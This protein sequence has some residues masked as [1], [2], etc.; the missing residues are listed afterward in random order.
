MIGF[1]KNNEKIITSGDSNIKFEELH[2][3]LSVKTNDPSF[4]WPFAIPSEP[5]LKTFNFPNS[6]DNI[7]NGFESEEGHTTLFGNKW[8]DGLVKVSSTK[9][10]F[11]NIVFSGK[12]GVLSKY[13]DKTITE[14]LGN[15]LI[16]WGNFEDVDN[17]IVFPEVAF[18]DFNGFYN[19]DLS[20]IIIPFFKLHYIMKKVFYSLGY[21]FVDEITSNDN[22][23]KKASI[24]C[25]RVE[26]YWLYNELIPIVDQEWKIKDFLPDW[27][28]SEFIQSIKI[29]F[30]C[31]VDISP[32]DKTITFTTFDRLKSKPPAHYSL[33]GDIESAPN[34][35]SNFGLSFSGGV[36]EG[37]HQSFPSGDYKGS[38][39]DFDSL[40]DI[41]SPSIG[42]YAFVSFENR[43]YEYVEDVVLEE[44]LWTHSHFPFH[45]YN[46]NSEN[47]L[48]T[49]FIPLARMTREYI[50]LSSS[51]NIEDNGSGKVR[52]TGL[53]L[54]TGVSVFLREQDQYST[55]TAYTVTDYD[56]DALHF[57]LDL[58]FINPVST[59]I[60][61]YI[62]IADRY[63]ILIPEPL[64]Y[65]TTLD[66]VSHEQKKADSKSE[67]AY[68][69][70]YHGYQD[71]IGS[72]ETYR[73]ASPDN[74][75]SNGI[76]I[77]NDCIR[78]FESNNWTTRF[79]KGFLLFSSTTRILKGTFDLTVDQLKN[80]DIFKV[81]RINNINVLLRKLKLTSGKKSF[82]KQEWE[83]YRLE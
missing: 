18:K 45:P 74:L 70:F 22:D 64:Y 56:A 58:N 55:H 35:V 53:Y 14:I 65:P 7:L 61:Y 24:C 76:Q 66:Q 33:T 10:N 39:N 4:T 69:T 5:N 44:Q 47:L 23:F 12:S 11:F 37:V 59:K 30:C 31:T 40:S 8:K 73:Y 50:S 25:N 29:L 83:G 62:S 79:W 71:N 41:S 43:Y 32:E 3:I 48:K 26:H 78:W 1:Y 52:V 17:Q 27:T 60:E 6:I 16:E 51:H 2:D 21:S 72:T 81:A 34:E 38:V 36:D 15:T 82:K 19:H 28:L 67:N 54:V 13:G 49:S 68:I 80:F 57:D 75:D 42:D 20:T 63:R 77:G 46:P 9:G